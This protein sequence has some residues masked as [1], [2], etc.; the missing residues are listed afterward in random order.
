MFFLLSRSMTEPLSA[1]IRRRYSVK[2]LRTVSRWSHPG[3]WREHNAL[4]RIAVM[5]N[6]GTSSREM[7]RFS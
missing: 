2:W 7:A 4:G 3:T 1:W 5:S 6:R